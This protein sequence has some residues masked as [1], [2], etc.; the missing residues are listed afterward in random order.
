MRTFGSGHNGIA[1]L[2]NPSFCYFVIFKS[3][4]MTSTKENRRSSWK[5]T[6]AVGINV[7]VGRECPENGIAVWAFYMRVKNSIDPCSTKTLVEEC[8]VVA[9][10]QLTCT[11]LEVTALVGLRCMCVDIVLQEVSSSRGGFVGLGI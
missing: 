6:P 5:V 2:M 11:V 10:S 9:K 4:G 8:Q 3:Y 1:L 7:V